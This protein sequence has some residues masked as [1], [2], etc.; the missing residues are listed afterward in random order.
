MQ[1]ELNSK[2][3]GARAGPNNLHSSTVSPPYPLPRNIINRPDPPRRMDSAP[4]STTVLKVQPYPNAASMQS[5]QLQG[6]PRS[7]TL[8]PSS[9]KSPVNL[10]QDGLNSPSVDLPIQQRPQSLPKNR[11]HVSRRQSGL[12][13]PTSAPFMHASRPS[14]KHARHGSRSSD[15]GSA[16]GT[17]SSFYPSPF[18]S[19]IEQLGR[20][21]RPLRSRFL[22]MELRRLRFDLSF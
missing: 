14:V 9:T 16:S 20:L 8:S 15:V 13:S 5:P 1:A 11:V 12:V 21:S 4:G 7:L 18:Q 6:T 2:N 22:T 17:Q 10:A 19:H 3:D